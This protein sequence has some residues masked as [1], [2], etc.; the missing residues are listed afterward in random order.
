MTELERDRLSYLLERMDF[1]IHAMGAFPSIEAQDK[2]IQAA[3]PGRAG[4][5]IADFR[6][7][8]TCL[9]DTQCRR[10]VPELLPDFPASAQQDLGSL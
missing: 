9:S 4:Q 3:D 10:P 7:N 1:A 8:P 5:L 6:S 2:V